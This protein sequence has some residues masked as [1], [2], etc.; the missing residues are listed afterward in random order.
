MFIRVHPWFVFIRGSCLSLVRDPWSGIRDPGS[1]RAS[2]RQSVVCTYPCSS[3]F[4]RGSYLSVF[5]RVH[6]WFV[7]IRV[8]VGRDPSSGIRDPIVLVRVNPGLYLS[9]FIRVHPWPVFIRV[10]PWLVLVRVDPWL[11]F[12]RGHD[13][14]GRD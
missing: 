11:V 3:V 5:I 14:N 10:H 9:V 2:P 4:I 13:A 8:A 12:I 6:P 7:L 1:D